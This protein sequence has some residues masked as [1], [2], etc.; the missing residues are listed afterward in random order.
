MIKFPIN[1]N[2]KWKNKYNEYLLSLLNNKKISIQKYW[3][4]KQKTLRD[5]YD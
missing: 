1:D 5:L 2:D 4:N 3:M